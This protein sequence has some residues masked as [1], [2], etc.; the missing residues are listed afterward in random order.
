MFGIGALC[1]GLAQGQGKGVEGM[2]T[3]RDLAGLRT[4]LCVWGAA[5]APVLQQRG[6]TV[7]VHIKKLWYWQLSISLILTSG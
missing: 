2:L 7:A 1:P 6:E 3:G 4:D 5:T